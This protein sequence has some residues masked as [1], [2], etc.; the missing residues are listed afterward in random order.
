VHSFDPSGKYPPEAIRIEP[1]FST[2]KYGQ[3]AIDFIRSREGN[4]QPFFC[5]CAFTAPHDPRTP[6]D[7]WLR[8]YDPKAITLPPNIVGQFFDSGPTPLGVK[9][10]F[11]IGSLDERD[12]LLLG[13]PRDINEIR[14]SIA[15]Y[16]GMISHMDQWI[17]KIHEA[18]ARI[19]QLGNTLIIH[20]ADHGLGLG[21]HGLMGKQ[22]LY[23][24]SLTVPLILAGPGIPAGN[25]SDALCYQHDLH[26]TLA[27]F[28]GITSPPG[29]FQ[30]LLS[31]SRKHVCASFRDMHRSVRSARHKLIEFN[32]HCQRR[33]QLFDLTEDPWET[34][35]LITDPQ[36]RATIHDLRL[37][38]A[39]W[40]QETGDD[41]TWPF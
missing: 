30:N 40:Q 21:Q 35:D 41:T 16:Y 18:A 5:Y 34:K 33:S 37:A 27:E 2:E 28:T 10:A 19:G 38:L 23:Q 26:P 7:A 25:V 11:D 13:T 4:G 24:H 36:H 20:T 9:P 39:Q 6:P 15:G 1:G 8:R 14:R 32:V 22:N 29:V 12:E 31:S 17:G 3:S